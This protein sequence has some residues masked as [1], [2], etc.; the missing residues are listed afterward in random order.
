MMETS[1]RQTFVV[2]VVVVVTLTRATFQHTP[3]AN[4]S[5]SVAS[6][7]GLVHLLLQ[8]LRLI[9]NCLHIVLRLFTLC[10]FV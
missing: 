10:Q 7:H 1:E 9:G 3:S 2:G 6:V 5:A 4:S 8:D